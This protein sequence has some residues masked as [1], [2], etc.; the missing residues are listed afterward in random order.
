MSSAPTPPGGLQ[1]AVLSTMT[2][3]EHGGHA[4]VL[5]HGWGAPGDDMVPLGRALIRPGTRVFAP[6]GPLPEFGDGR[7]WWRLGPDE[8]PAWAWDDQPPADHR[9]NQLVT[10]AR[11]AVLALLATVREQFVPDTVSLAG[12]SQGAM[13]ALDVGL[14]AEAGV[15]RVAAL[16]GVV[17]AD[18]LAALHA[19]GPRRPRFLVAHG[20]HD[21]QVPFAGGEQAHDLLVR[22]GYDVAWRPFDGGHDIPGQI[23]TA[24]DT[25]LFDDPPTRD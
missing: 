9:P 8:R 20:R 19:P 7:A 16:S 14:L 21:E 5:L 4:V 18:S 15:D 17:L 24:L 12:F 22:H 6:A 10:A 3:E 2:E 13:L 1:V 23:V 25:F 11:E